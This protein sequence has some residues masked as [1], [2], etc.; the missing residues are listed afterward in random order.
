MCFQVST[1]FWGTMDHPSKIFDLSL[2]EKPQTKY[3]KFDDCYVK[4][5]YRWCAVPLAMLWSS[6]FNQGSNMCSR[7]LLSPSVLVAQPPPQL[8]MTIGRVV[9]RRLVTP[10]TFA[11]SP[12]GI[13]VIWLSTRSQCTPSKP[14]P[15]SAQGTALSCKF[16]HSIQSF[17][18]T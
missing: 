9:G 11:R 14:P 2:R 7:L 8:L 3:F 16:S 18:L 13:I 1:P 6:V 17:D 10:A 15:L 5:I 12:Q 4:V